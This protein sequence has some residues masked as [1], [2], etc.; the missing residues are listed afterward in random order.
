MVY[1]TPK[2]FCQILITIGKA[3]SLDF[4]AAFYGTKFSLFKPSFV[5]SALLWHRLMGREVLSVD[6]NAPPRKLRAYAHCRK[7]QVQIAHFFFSFLDFAN[8]GVPVTADCFA[9]TENCRISM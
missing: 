8:Y 3:T 5:P 9:M 6:I 2:L 1:L 7:Q 4:T